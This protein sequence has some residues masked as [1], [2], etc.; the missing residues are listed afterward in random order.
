MKLRVVKASQG[1]QWVR[2][3][4]L[5]G[6]R[7]PFNLVGLLGMVACAAM[8]LIGLP[9]VGPLIVVGLMPLVWMGF[10]LA[11]RRVLNKER[12]TPAV[13]IEPVR[14]PDSPRRGFAQLGGAYVVATL[15]VMQLAQWMGPGSEVLGDAFDAAKE[16]GDI[17]SN[18]QVQQDLLWRM[19]LTLPVSLLFW[20]T[21]ALVLWARM[22]VGKSLF[23]SAVATWRNLGAF[24]LYGAA[25]AGVVVGVGLFDRLLLSI[26]PEP[27]V[28]SVLTVA[29]GLWVTASFYASL[30]FTVVDC[31]EA[32]QEDQDVSR[33]TPSS[34][35][36]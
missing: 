2:Q 19:V 8:L 30:Y 15:V 11:T 26:I 18:P 6:R 9:V 29:M 4:L 1:L 35:Q 13:L 25:W 12:I 22:P 33:V 34:G 36:A 32:P 23:F 10:M 31:F 27:A 7:Q 5:V 14:T 17:L 21:P 24:A 16:T 20:H 28:G 3:G